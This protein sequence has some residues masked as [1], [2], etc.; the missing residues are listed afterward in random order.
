[1]RDDAVEV[2]VGLD[3]IDLQCLF[4]KQLDAGT[5]RIPA[6]PAPRRRTTQH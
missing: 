6:P 4:Y 2:Y 5:F 3:P 1:V